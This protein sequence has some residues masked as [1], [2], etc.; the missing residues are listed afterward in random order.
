MTGDRHRDGYDLDTV[1]HFIQDLE[2]G[3]ISDDNH[4]ILMGLIKDDPDVCELYFE[5][6]E[7]VALLKQTVKNREA[8]GVLPVSDEM[9]NLA[10]RRSAIVSLT[11]GLAAVLL[12]SVGFLIFQVSHRPS[13][14][15]EW[16]VMNESVDAKYTITYTE[17]Q[18]RDVQNL[19]VGDKISLEQGLVRFT[20]P[21]GVKAII[22]GPSKL[23]LTSD[24]SLKMDGGAAWFRVPKA[25]HGFT[26]QTERLSVVDL[27]TEFGVWFD[28]NEMLQVHVAKGKV[29][30]EP[31]LKAL[32]KF[33]LVEDKAMSFDEYGR[34]TSVKIAT[35]LFRQEF[36][37]SMP[38]LHWSFDE[39]VDGEFQADGTMPGV[40]GYQAKLRHL[41]DD[42]SQVDIT[43][44]QV[45]G[46]HGQAFSMD[47]KGLF[48][49]TAFP[50]IGGN[51]PR[52]LSM[53]IRHRKEN[54][55]RGIVSPY[56][57]WGTPKGSGL[58]KVSLVTKGVD[59]SL[60]TT[61]SAIGYATAFNDKVEGGWIHLASVYTGKL[62]CDG[63]P[64]VFHYVNGSLI[65]EADSKR[66]GKNRYL[67]PKRVIDTDILS[68]DAMPVRFGASVKKSRG[69]NVVI[70]GDIDEVYLFRGVLN[71]SQIK[72]LMVNNRLDF[73]S[74]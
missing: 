48:A 72:E 15:R 4:T 60:H 11:Y 23:E 22:E 27:G 45:K 59:N 37:E 12:I 73:F 20:F 41:S 9:I 16:I 63:Y 53:W 18:D 44:H 29:R 8:M 51:T 55:T 38:Y 31:V 24:L 32:K 74:N 6:M 70:D 69:K 49:E 26:V 54:L 21:S 61:W 5:H 3:V 17:D 65:S 25:G 36:T 14:D 13:E 71:D 10:R 58:W 67:L 42:V 30:V 35:S 50:G 28:G 39:L 47:G 56:C 34:G 2:D 33:E 62:R 19:Q 40:G 57:V 66:T 1:D 46:K 52:T 64:E 68:E 43:K 7:T